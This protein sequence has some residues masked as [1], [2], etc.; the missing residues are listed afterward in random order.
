MRKILG[1]LIV[2]GAIGASAAESG[3]KIGYIDMQSALQATSTGKRAKEN[4]EKEF[5]EKKKELQKREADLKKM[6]EDF[7]K[8]TLV[9]SD[10]MKL[11]KQQELREEMMKYQDLVGKSQI[12]MQKKERD[13]VE[14]ILV[15]LRKIIDKVAKDENYTVILEKSE[16]SVLWA[17]KEID[18]TERVVKDYE[19]SQASDKK[20]K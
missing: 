12:G 7:E 3:I 13:L 18:L 1:L 8:K 10:E 4:L 14:P 19:K 11:K 17:K 20:K 6:N 9:L 15:D 5:N 16:Q 2:V